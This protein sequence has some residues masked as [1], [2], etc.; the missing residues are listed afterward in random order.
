VPKFP[1]PD[2]AIG[3]A[4]P[5]MKAPLDSRSVTASWFSSVIPSLIRT[6]DRSSAAPVPNPPIG[7]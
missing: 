2:S 4:T 7:T 3:F 1:V 5:V 6:I